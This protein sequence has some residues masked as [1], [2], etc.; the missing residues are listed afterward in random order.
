[1]ALDRTIARPY[2]A[3][4]FEA[5]LG[6]DMLDVWSA[7][8]DLLARVAGH[9][10][11]QQML[12]DPRLP[13]EVKAER[14]CSVLEG[15]EQSGSGTAQLRNFV[16]LLAANG[17]L[18]AELI[19]HISQEFEQLERRAQKRY[20]VFVSTAFALDQHQRAELE[21]K[22]RV[23]LGGEV[24][25]HEQVDARLLGGAVIRHGDQVLDG[26]LRGRLARLAEGLRQRSTR[27]DTRAMPA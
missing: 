26:S 2:A 19:A 23:R 9:E 4:L 1:M 12:V 18:E 8:L 15:R 13:G 16:H 21:D 20:Q 24:E 7:Q 25:I 5:A 14:L 22:L 17:R 3:A 27:Q 11:M 10:T 6:R